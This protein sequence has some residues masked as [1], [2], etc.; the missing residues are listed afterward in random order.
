MKK[1]ELNQATNHHQE[2]DHPRRVGFHAAGL[3]VG[4]AINIDGC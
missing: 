4:G 2:P 1:T 3:A